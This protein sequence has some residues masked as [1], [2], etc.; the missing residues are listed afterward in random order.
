MSTASTES[1]ITYIDGD[2]APPVSRL[3]GG[4]VAEQSC[5]LE[6]AYLLISGNLA[7]K[8]ELDKFQES[9]MHHTMINE[10]LLRSSRVHHD[11]HP[12]A[13]CR[14]VAS[15]AAFYHDST[16]INDPRHREI[17]CTGSLRNC[18]PLRRR[19]KHTLG[20]RRLSAQ[21]PAYCANMLNMF[22]AVP[23]SLCDRSGRGEALDLLFILHATTTEREHLDRA[24]RR[25]HGHESYARFRPACPLCGSAHGGANEAVI[26]MLDEIGSVS[27]I[28]ASWRASR[29]RRQRAPDGFRHRV[30]KNF[31][32]APRSSGACAIG[33]WRSSGAPTI[34][35]RSGMKLEK[36]RSR[37]ITSC[38]ANCIR[39]SILFRNHL[40]RARHPRSMFTVM[41]AIARTAGWGSLQEMVSDPSMRIGRRAALHG[42]TQR[43]YLTSISAE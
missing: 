33:C 25:K 5:F 26:D 34:H 11:A 30:Y 23:A 37:T 38:P 21:R 2:R 27:N 18:R 32:R 41:F 22:F 42:T 7:T 29:T 9:I 4:T 24:P 14:R 17:F 16:D 8:A 43:D 35:V 15:M 13:M 3:S 20:Q 36:S 19:Y 1:K 12:M 10:H 28:P 40:Q 6:V 31:D 39:T